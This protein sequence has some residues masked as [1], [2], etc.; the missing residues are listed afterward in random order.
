MFEEQYRHDNERL[1]ANPALLMEIQ[2]KADAEKRANQRRAAIVRYGAAAAAVVLVIGG[3]VGVLASRG[4]KNSATESAEMAADSASM[5]MVASAAG[6]AADGGI[7]DYDALFELVDSL[8]YGNKNTTTGTMTEEIA[9]DSAA[10][11]SAPMGTENSGSTSGSAQDATMDLD[12]GDG[13]A[14]EDYSET[15]V[16]VKGVDEADIIKTDG[17]YIY[18]TAGGQ[19]VILSAEGADTR[20]LSTVNFIDGENWWGNA[21][22]MFLSGDRLV[23]VTQ[24]SNTVWVDSGNGKVDHYQDQTRVLIYDVSNREKPKRIASLG[25]SGNYLSARR[26]GDFV[27]VVTSQYMYS[28]YRN[29]V[30]TYCPVV[31]TGDLGNA[32]DV[33]DIYVYDRANEPLYTVIGAID[34][35]EATQYAAS[36][37]ILGSTSEM[38][39]NANHLLLAASEERYDTSDIAPD[40]SGK[41]VQITSSVSD[42]RLVLFTIDGASIARTATATVRGTILNQFAMDE[43][44]GAFRIVTTVNEWEERIYTD[45]IDRYE[46]DSK[47]YNCL[48]T[49]DAALN[50]LGSIENLA[51]DEWVESVRFDGPIGYFVTFRQTD[52][53]FT[54]DL[55]DPKKPRILS[56]LKIPGFSEYLHVFDT[57]LLLGIGYSADEETGWREGVKLSMF[58]VSNPKAVAEIASLRMDAGWS[59]IGSNHK[60][61][62]VD[63]AKNII[64][65]PADNKYYVFSYDAANKTF[66]QQATVSVSDDVW[67]YDMRGVF[68]GD[69]LYVVSESAVIVISLT[70]Y[71]RIAKVSLSYR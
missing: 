16:Q 51:K 55:S 45:G 4:M 27:Y 30:E 22:E 11:E 15:N 48:Y 57:G 32:L 12:R 36:K 10:P 66:V 28:V 49:L 18:Y 35:K 46:H 20:V 59:M 5:P 50:P 39:A 1:H 44:D 53:L 69:N 47:T 9:T 34:L 54:V 38:Y 26:I 14:T 13:A 70:D 68:I 7:T 33:A 19:F 37:A 61:V 56:T 21:S 62:L 63:S 58:D 65:F 67:S 17:K 8:Q 3:T 24:R 31:Y 43:Y 52:P 6:R 60:A 29:A 71:E 23:I 64:A 40:K 42:T 2:K 41:N 25:Q